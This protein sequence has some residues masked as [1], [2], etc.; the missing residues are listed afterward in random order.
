VVKHGQSIQVVCAESD[1][2]LR[3]NDATGRQVYSQ[4][5]TSG[6][7]SITLPLSVSGIYFYNIQNTKGKHVTG[8]LI[9]Q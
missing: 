7:Q 6:V 5:L 1:N 8:K 4:V 2:I 9:I 3:I